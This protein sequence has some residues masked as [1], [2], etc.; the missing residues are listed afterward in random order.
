MP[1]KSTKSDNGVLHPFLDQVEEICD[2]ASTYSHQSTLISTNLTHNEPKNLIFENEL[3][4]PKLK[5][6]Q[7]SMKFEGREKGERDWS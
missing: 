3:K 5:Q 2:L 7:R 4:N 1:Q 6:E